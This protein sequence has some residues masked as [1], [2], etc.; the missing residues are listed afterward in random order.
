MKLLLFLFMISSPVFAGQVPCEPSSEPIEAKVM[1][2][3]IL[4]TFKV[5]HWSA[6]SDD[7]EDSPCKGKVPTLEEM[8]RANNKLLDSPKVE[9]REIV[10]AEFENE[11]EQMLRMFDLLVQ[12]RRFSG[13]GYILPNQK[14]YSHLT[15]GSCKKV[16]CALNQ[17]FG[18][19]YSENAMYLLSQY[20]LN[21]SPVGLGNDK[22]K[23]FSDKEL[24]SIHQSVADLPKSLFP[25]RIAKSF[26]RSSLSNGNTLGN[27]TIMLFEGITKYNHNE[28][29]GICT[30]EF[31]HNFSD[32]GKLDESPDWLNISGWIDN[33][34]K[35]ERDS[36]RN[37]TF[38]SKYAMAN[39]GEDFAE[40]VV[41]YRYN[42]DALRAAS[43]EKYDFIKELVFKGREYTEGNEKSCQ[44]QTLLEVQMEATLN[45][46]VK[47]FERENS[48]FK[49]DQSLASCSKEIMMRFDG[50]RDDD[51]KKCISKIY[52][53]KMLEQNWDKISSEFNYPEKAK[54][55]INENFFDMNLNIGDDFLDQKMRE[56]DAELGRIEEDSMKGL[57]G[58]MNLYRKFTKETNVKDFCEND[59]VKYGYLKFR[60][61]ENGLES[62]YLNRNRDSI[63]ERVRV[64]CNK[65]F[66]TMDDLKRRV[67]LSDI[68]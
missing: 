48:E 59:I 32:R 62:V 51:L 19:S 49:Y 31:A 1:A 4:K 12:K 15:K 30:H 46:D 54:E 24:K 26:R 58:T 38:V 10:G 43:P 28:K 52:Q 33:G 50:R 63:D 61:L 65:A 42:P 34:G 14:D 60:E 23:K 16:R 25:I 44:G 11:S 41:A 13:E 68:L 36:S 18:E 47:E 8:K 5:S 35:W 37:H 64:A 3:E 55:L 45:K 17:L 6:S 22:T 27:A 21:V 40:S 67:E 39:P 29:T 9:K 20:E 57:V 2:E 53:K 66:K 56:I 7:I